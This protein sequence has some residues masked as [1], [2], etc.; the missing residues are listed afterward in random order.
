MDEAMD[1]KDPAKLTSVKTPLLRSSSVGSG[2]TDLANTGVTGAVVAFL[3]LGGRV[4][5]GVGHSFD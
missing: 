1:T 2:V 4:T 3:V 5:V